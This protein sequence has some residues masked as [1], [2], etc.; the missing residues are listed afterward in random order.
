MLW[1]G[2]KESLAGTLGSIHNI[3]YLQD[4]VRA[5]RRHIAQGTFADFVRGYPASFAAEPVPD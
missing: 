4:L 1:I 5:A 3:H 2:R